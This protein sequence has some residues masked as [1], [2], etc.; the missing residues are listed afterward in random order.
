MRLL[1]MAAALAACTTSTS[2]DP[3]AIVNGIYT[4]DATSQTD[5]CNPPRYAGSFT[6]P[7]EIGSNALEISDVSTFGPKPFAAADSL[8][9]ASGY[10]LHLPEPAPP[11][12]H[13]VPAVPTATRSTWR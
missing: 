6:V 8:T 2:I 13:V 12:I 3:T 9:T 7:I 1:L 5:T 4:L 11:V 10:T